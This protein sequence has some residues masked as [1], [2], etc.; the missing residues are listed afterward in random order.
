MPSGLFA[1]EGGR[2][3]FAGPTP[4]GFQTYQK[5]HAD[6]LVRYMFSFTPE[7]LGRLR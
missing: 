4:A 1:K 2:W 5:D 7:E 3:V 6:L